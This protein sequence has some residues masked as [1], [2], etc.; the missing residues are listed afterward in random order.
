MGFQSYYNINEELWTNYGLKG[1]AIYYL[2]NR[3]LS[4]NTPHVFDSDFF[5][6]I[7]VYRK[8][9]HMR[10]LSVLRKYRIVTVWMNFVG[11]SQGLS[12]LNPTKH[13]LPPDISF[14]N[15]LLLRLVETLPK[16]KL[17]R[18]VQNYIPE[19]LSMRLLC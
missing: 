15:S 13:A 14:I 9:A 2:W 3:G 6:K 1:A 12:P 17:N 7:T 10:T 4:P 16:E 11:I 8:I 5:S 18:Q 19:N